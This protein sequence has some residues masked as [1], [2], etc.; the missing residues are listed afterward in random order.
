VNENNMRTLQHNTIASAWP[1]IAFILILM[2]T[3]FLILV[4]GHVMEPFM[5]LMDSP[6]T[7]VG[8]EI[9]TPRALMSWFFQL[10]WPKGVLLTV[11]IGCALALFMEYQKPTYKT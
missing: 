5:N 1:V 11:F 3:S 2:I 6:N 8:T 9:S 7:D 10:V 4:L